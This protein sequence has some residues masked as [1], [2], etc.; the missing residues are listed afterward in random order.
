MPAKP[1]LNAS[2]TGFVE[3]GKRGKG[4]LTLG[5]FRPDAYSLIASHRRAPRGRAN[6]ESNWRGIL[7]YFAPAVELGLAARQD[8]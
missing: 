8:Y 5:F 2:S 7:K 4:R 3:A 6:D 1:E